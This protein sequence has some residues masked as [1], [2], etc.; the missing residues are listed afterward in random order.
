M[1]HT[2]S[3]RN[4]SCSTAT[5]HQFDLTHHREPYTPRKH[6]DFQV[7]TTSRPFH[8]H[9]APLLNPNSYLSHP[10]TMIDYPY[11]VPN[12]P[13]TLNFRMYPDSSIPP[14]CKF[15]LFPSRR[16]IRMRYLL[17]VVCCSQCSKFVSCFRNLCFYT[18]IIRVR[19]L[20]SP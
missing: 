14:V 5:S 15:K 12:T 19:A 1:A 17:P 6:N 10:P 20:D 13:V 7:S 4:I 3:H 11:P 2:P 16:N 8:R 9:N 18:S